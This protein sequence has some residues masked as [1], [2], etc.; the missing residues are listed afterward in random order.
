MKVYRYQ[1]IHHA[2]KESCE[3]MNCCIPLY[4]E[5]AIVIEKYSLNK[6]EVEA[7][8]RNH[9]KSFIPDM[10]NSSDF[11]SYEIED[12]LDLISDFCVCPKLIHISYDEIDL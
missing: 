9:L 10:Y 5:P 8:A 2:V 11:D 3:C 1:V 4:E 7:F 12:I 6:N